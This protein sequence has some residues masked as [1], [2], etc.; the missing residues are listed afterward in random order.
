MSRASPAKPGTM[1][2][3]PSRASCERTSPTSVPALAR[4]MLP[5]GV[6]GPIMP[7]VTTGMYSAGSP[8]RAMNSSFCRESALWR[9]ALATLM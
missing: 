3:A 6:M 7:P 1:N 4:A 5:A 9:S 2:G 8:F